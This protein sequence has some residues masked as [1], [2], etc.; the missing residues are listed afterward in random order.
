M[1]K[2]LI[3]PKGRG[4]RGYLQYIKANLLKFYYLKLPFLSTNIKK[5]SFYK[6]VEDGYNDVLYRGLDLDRNSNIFDIGGFKGEFTEEIQKICDCNIYIFEPVKEYF[7][8]IIAKQNNNPKVHIYHF[9]LG[10]G[11]MNTKINI[12][13]S[14]SSVFKEANVKGEYQEIKIESI[15][16]FIKSN[17]INK[18]DLMKI[19]IEGGEYD[20]LDALINNQ[21]MINTI[22]ILLIQFH[23]FVPDAVAKRHTLQEYLTLTHKNVFDYPFIWEKWVRK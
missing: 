23:D 9:G 21:E 6:F 17:N 15:I 16:K 12:A 8:Q 18:I 1:I 22:K 11:A 5:K 19:N 10:G 2:Y 7:D 13:G 3:S 4:A 14:S 20:L